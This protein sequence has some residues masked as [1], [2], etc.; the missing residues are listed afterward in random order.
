M[1]IKAA[2]GTCGLQKQVLEIPKMSDFKDK[3]IESQEVK[4]SVQRGVAA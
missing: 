3:R 4:T 1:F 2:I